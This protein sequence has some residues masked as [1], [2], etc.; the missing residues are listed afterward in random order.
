M[1][2]VFFW[3]KASLNGI[4]LVERTSWPFFPLFLYKNDC[5]LLFDDEEETRHIYFTQAFLQFL[6][7]RSR[8]SFLTMSM[9]DNNNN[10]A[11]GGE[12][13]NGD[14][15]S[16]DENVDGDNGEVAA[17]AA[18]AAPRAARG[19][20]Y[21]AIEDYMNAQAWIK[22]SED[23]I[24]GSKQKQSAFK[25]KL[26]SAYNLVKKHQIELDKREAERPTHL[27]DST[28]N[29][30]V[31]LEEYGERTGG[32]L[33]QNFTK[34]ISPDVIKFMGIAKCVSIS[35][36]VHLVRWRFSFVFL[37]WCTSCVGGF[38]F[39]FCFF[40]SLPDLI[41][42]SLHSQNKKKSGESDQTYEERLLVIWKERFGKPFKY[43]ACWVFLK[44]KPKFIT[45]AAEEEEKSTKKKSS[46]QER[47]V[48]M[49]YAKKLKRA[50][51]L[52]DRIAGKLGVKTP[53]DGNEVGGNNAARGSDEMRLAITSLVDIAKDGLSSWQ[54]SMLM[55]HASDD[56]KQQLANA[57]MK[58][59]IL[60]VEK[61][62]QEM[63]NTINGNIN[64]IKSE[65]ENVQNDDDYTSSSQS[66]VD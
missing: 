47:P 48:G 64:D 20:T 32:S 55:A 53:P 54:T 21:T 19:A 58:Q 43:H 26:E 46:S 17:A 40:L 30:L 25:I 16:F 23:S 52:V 18:A 24:K 51:E 44:D 56:V 60:Q 50:D 34:K 38:R 10:R 13:N 14:V 63:E 29:G 15:G 45:Y 65:T 11:A 4:A 42:F 3:Y 8:P 9:N 12:D 33:F 61:N 7:T 6:Q 59:K 49:K 22:A 66:S 62:N 41:R 2:R 28:T 5:L 1:Y 39:C 35:L 36:L 37:C 57:T 27:R 31:R